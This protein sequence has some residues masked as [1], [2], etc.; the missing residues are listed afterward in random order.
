MTRSW[1]RQWMEGELAELAGDRASDVEREFSH[2]V[3]QVRLV[4]TY[5]ASSEHV[6]PVEFRTYVSRLTQGLGQGLLLQWVPYVRQA[7]RAAYQ[8]RARAEGRQDF[9]F[10]DLDAAGQLIV[11]ADRP[12]YFPIYYEYPENRVPSFLGLDL[13]T[14]ADKLALFRKACDAGEVIVLSRGSHLP[15]SSDD[16]SFL[17]IVPVFHTPGRSDLPESHRQSL[18]GL[19]IGVLRVQDYLNRALRPSGPRGVIVRIADSPEPGT[20]LSCWL[21]EAPGESVREVAPSAFRET[22]STSCS[23]SRS[24][25]IGDRQWLVTCLSTPAF[26][27]ARQRVT[28][29]ILLILGLA[30]TGLVAGHFRRTRDYTQG[31]MEV[32]ERLVR[33]IGERERIASSLKEN[34]R[35]LSIL[36]ANLPGMVYRCRNDRNWTMVFV[37]EGCVSLTGY[38]PADLLENAKTSYAEVIHPEDR[39]QVWD[40]VQAA[41]AEGTEFE[42][43]YRIRTAGGDEKWVWERGRGVFSAEGEL[44]FL[45]G[46][47]ADITEQKRAQDEL[48]RY[49]ENLEARVAERTRQLD[50]SKEQLR[51]SERLASLGTFAAGIAHEI[52]N[53]VGTMLLAAE[54]ALELRK[55]PG[56]EAVVDDCLRGIVSEARRCG[57]VIQ[58]VL[59]FARREQAPKTPTSIEAVIRRSV[60]MIA[61]QA[62]RQEATVSVHLGADLPQISLNALQMEQVFVNLLRN[63]LEAGG[64]G[65]K[66]EVRADVADDRLRVTVS[67]NGPGIPRDHLP[68]VFDPFFTTRRERGGTGLGL[69][70]AHA[71]IVDHDGQISVNSRPGGG[72]TFTID[73]PLRS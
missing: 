18:T 73:L 69:S 64:K 71:I 13:S 53:P 4:A 31:L 68:R 35:F 41:L 44:M 23:Q 2:C 15:Q 62:Q 45:E 20:S 16:P 8:D 55:M 12:E 1:E 38:L 7:E 66:L 24:V 48:A 3:G 29:W 39:L 61:P 19:V 6:T 47:V 46:F 10:K 34:E 50:E 70:L 21:Y 14:D 51:R 22:L 56:S 49:R 54:N 9:E 25:Q 42:L 43:T 40:K 32:N 27:A 57:A 58:G 11:A 59:Q 33:E 28:Q 26:E 17:V 65:V 30:I 5:F 52:N 37:S 60:E 63:A 36:L 72:T 67:D